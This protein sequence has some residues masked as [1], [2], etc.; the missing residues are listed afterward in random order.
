MQNRVSNAGWGTKPRGAEAGTATLL[1]AD[2]GGHGNMRMNQFASHEPNAIEQFMASFKSG[3]FGVL[4]VMSKD[5][6]SSRVFTLCMMCFDFVQMMG[7]PLNNS[8]N[9]PWHT[10]SSLDELINALAL[11]DFNV[12]AS[13]LSIS[14]M[15]FY[16]SLVWVLG[17]LACAIWV[18][19]SFAQEN[20]AA[21][22]PLKLLRLIAQL[23]TTALF[24]PITGVLMSVFTCNSGESWGNADIKC[25]DS[26]HSIITLLVS[27]IIILFGILS[28]I[29]VSAFFDRNP[30]S[31]NITSMV[32]GRVA[33]AMILLKAALALVFTQVNTI[34]A[35]WTA[36]TCILTGV[37]WLSMFVVFLPYYSHAMNKMQAAFAFV[38]LWAGICLGLAVWRDAT[39]S[40][41]SGFTFLSAIPLVAFTGSHIVDLRYRMYD[42]R[43]NKQL[44]SPFF[45][46]L[47]TRRLLSRIT[48]T[49]SV[50]GGLQ[51]GG[52][53]TKL[54]DDEEDL[55]QE[56]L[57][58]VDQIYGEAMLTFPE[59]P[60]LNVFIAHY[61]DIYRQN[62]HLESS[63]LAAAE[64]KDPAMDAAFIVF[65]RKR[66]LA[67]AELQ[68]TAS[69]A[70]DK[71]DVIS[72]V[73]FE[74]YR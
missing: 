15:L 42:Y 57:R 9:L 29:V 30:L 23:T 70:A 14:G 35:W 51:P 41:V 27:I 66:Q 21:L 45:V 48:H 62:R 7:F 24:I 64:M 36:I 65:Q 59:S 31:D 71:L 4:F 1:A 13:S 73:R 46:E 20:F 28:A 74:K 32:H 8:K 52:R 11:L 53:G 25:W 18:G 60:M 37:A 2:T 56:V 72:R 40:N 3:I 49:V 17:L 67:E 58:E 47:Q 34:S 63:H 6:S 68:T 69:S 61:L 44:S 26:I 39:E 10:S 33:V 50:P 43:T 22:W 12:M 54:A 16:V 5:A 38:Y 19:Y 55:R